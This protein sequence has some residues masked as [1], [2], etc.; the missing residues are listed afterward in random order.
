MAQAAFTPASFLLRWLTALILVFA[1]FNPT[2]Y[3]F[4]R[5]VEPMDGENLPLKALAGI[6]LLILYVIFLRATWRSIGPIGVALAAALLG[7]LIWVGI[8][9]GL[10]NISR[11]TVM[12]WVLLFACA[13]ILAIGISWSHIRRRISGQADMDDVD[14]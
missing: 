4:F 6:L 9:F 11:P 7:A 5:W 2:Q 12:T 14:E 13:T 1:T 10:F 8:D 3:S